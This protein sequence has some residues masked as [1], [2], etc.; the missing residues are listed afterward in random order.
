MYKVCMYECMS[1][2]MNSTGVII[3]FGNAKKKKKGI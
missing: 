1:Q 2:S 3:S